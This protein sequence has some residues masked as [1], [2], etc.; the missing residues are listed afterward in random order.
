[1]GFRIQSHNTQYKR[2]RVKV[3]WV[4]AVSIRHTYSFL[5]NHHHA[6]ITAATEEA[7]IMMPTVSRQRKRRRIRKG[8]YL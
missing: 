2:D 4:V 1:M 5:P 6:H 8:I 3:G 7:M